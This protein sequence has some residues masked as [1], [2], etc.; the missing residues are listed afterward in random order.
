ML[1]QVLP[2]NDRVKLGDHVGHRVTVT[3]VI[4][5]ATN[6]QPG[7][8]NEGVSPSM[9]STGMDTQPTPAPREGALATA[10]TIAQPLV[11]NAVKMLSVRCDAGK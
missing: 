5:A 4:R 9:R 11:V 2:A 1:Y 10:V 3:A 7:R 6:T 8:S